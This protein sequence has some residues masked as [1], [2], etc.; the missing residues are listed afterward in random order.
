MIFVPVDH[1]ELT[2][3]I[4]TRTPRAHTDLTCG[5]RLFQRKS[6]DNNLRPSFITDIDIYFMVINLQRSQQHHDSMIRFILVG[7]RGIDTVFDY[8]QVFKDYYINSNR[9]PPRQNN[10]PG[11]LYSRG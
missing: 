4:N 8:K 9:A 11:V 1:K 7:S 5:V 2:T 10:G 6:S 3:G